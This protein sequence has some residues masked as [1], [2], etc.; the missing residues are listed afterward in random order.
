MKTTF[1]ILILLVSQV[2]AADTLCEAP[3]L[4]ILLTNDD[5]V[6][7]VGIEEMHHAL[8]DAGHR[9]HRIA[10]N[11]NYSGSGASMTFRNVTVQDLSTDKYPNVFAIGGSPA[12]SVFLGIT[13]LLDSDEPIDLI[14]SGIN[15]GP[16]LGRAVTASGTVGAVLLGLNTFSIPGIAISTYTLDA[17]VE[18]TGYRQ[19]F[20][21]VARFVARITSAVGCDDLSLLGTKQALHISYPALPPGE[22]KGVRMTHQAIGLGYRSLFVKNPDG[23][24]DYQTRPSEADLTKEDGNTALFR[25]GYITIVPIDGDLTVTPQFDTRKILSIEP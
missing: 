18:S 3:P 2:S 21:N 8:L 9:V 19:H 6:T 24:Y 22:I 23:N 15:N 1:T 7:T 13:E 5:G 12:T 11:R 4:N 16:N 25:E 14:V 17:D 20:V 10:P